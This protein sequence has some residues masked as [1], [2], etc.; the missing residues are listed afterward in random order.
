MATKE[1]RWPGVMWLDLDGGGA[2]DYDIQL[3]MRPRVR[4]GLW[5][6]VVAA[7]VWRVAKANA[8]VKRSSTVIR[9]QAQACCL[10]AYACGC[11]LSICPPPLHLQLP[12]LS[13]LSKTSWNHYW[14]HA[15]TSVAWRG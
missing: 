13:I 1:A 5:V 2:M 3:R 12:S 14:Q 4:C 11:G 7:L 15:Q 10:G 8:E 9:G 6:G